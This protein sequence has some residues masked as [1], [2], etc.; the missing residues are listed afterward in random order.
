MQQLQ[1]STQ[2]QEQNFFSKSK[3]PLQKWLLMLYLWAREY[4]VSDAAEE[5]EISSRVAIDIYQ[6][7]REVCTDI[8]LQIILGGPGVVV[9][10]DE[11]LFRHKPKVA[12]NQCNYQMN[13]NAVINPSC[14][15]TNMKTHTH[16]KSNV[17]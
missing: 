10:I 12:G 4:P 1:V 5:A 8:L 2:N 7:L 14:R 9:H 3:L 6:C 16:K 11:S 13:S 15:T 17:F